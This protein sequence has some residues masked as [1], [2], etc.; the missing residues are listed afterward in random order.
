V[1]AL[2]SATA[3]PDDERN[4]RSGAAEHLDQ[5]V[6]AEAIDLAAGEIAD[7]RLGDA[8]EPWRLRPG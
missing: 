2:C 8:Q 4:T 3:V 6:D 1:F 7:P 5:C